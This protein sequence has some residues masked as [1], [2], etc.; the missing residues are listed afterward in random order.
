MGE[1]ISV[2]T[3]DD[4]TVDWSIVPS[5]PT[6]HYD[7]VDENW[8]V[9]STSDY[10]T[11]GANY[12]LEGYTFPA[13]GPTAM[14]TV[15][16]IYFDLYMNTIDYTQIPGLY[17]YLYLGSTH[18]AMSYYQVIT[19]GTWK[20]LRFVFTGLNLT[21]TQYNTVVLRVLTFPGVDTWPAPSEDFSG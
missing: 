5:S 3:G 7:K 21:K 11:E 16:T 12:Q 20:K 2:P 14:G 19:N 10:V 6:T 9:P 15:H 18:H 8:N 17:V 1:Q 13:D 4:S